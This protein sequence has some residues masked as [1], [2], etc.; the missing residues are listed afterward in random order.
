MPLHGISL[1][2]IIILGKSMT[3]K[4]YRILR[5]GNKVGGDIDVDNK[6]ISNLIT[7]A[8]DGFGKFI[9]NEEVI[10]HVVRRDAL[11]IA[12]KD[13]KEIGFSTF[14]RN[15]SDMYLGGAVVIKK[16]QNN[17]LYGLLTKVRIVEAINN[18]ITT[19][20]TNTQN[21]SVEQGI[22]KIFKEAKT[23]GKIQ[24]FTMKREMVPNL[25]GR[26]LTRQI[27]KSTNSDLNLIYSHLNYGNGDAFRITIEISLKNKEMPPK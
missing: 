20:T 13:D 18:K 3:N 21:P 10:E 16:E 2:L 6:T 23:L 7:V 19:V 26:M 27:P 4:K 1:L 24:D 15:G 9:S 12:Y 8:R 11:F 5:V 25:Y 14:S 22:V 17:G